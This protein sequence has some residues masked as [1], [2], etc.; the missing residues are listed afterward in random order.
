MVKKILEFCFLIFNWKMV[1]NGRK[2]V[3]R[4]PFTSDRRGLT[5]LE[6]GQG[7]CAGAVG[8]NQQKPMC[9]LA[10]RPANKQHKPGQNP[11]IECPDLAM[12][13]EQGEKM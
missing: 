10:H 1:E 4:L 13:A 2:C 7:D 9:A 3:R 12:R 8:Q 5:T 6:T 11:K